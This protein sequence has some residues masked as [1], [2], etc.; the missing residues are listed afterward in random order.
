MYQETCSTTDMLERKTCHELKDTQN[1]FKWYTNKFRSVLLFCRWVTASW[2]CLETFQTVP[3]AK[4]ASLGGVCPICPVFSCHYWAPASNTLRLHIS[5]FWMA[6]V[7]QTHFCTRPRGRKSQKLHQTLHQPVSANTLLRKKV[8]AV[9][10]PHTQ[11]LS[12]TDQW[13]KRYFPF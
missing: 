4:N 7:K 3:D 10:I 8:G 13:K 11:H 1:Y 5:A 2:K 9:T 6:L 12:W